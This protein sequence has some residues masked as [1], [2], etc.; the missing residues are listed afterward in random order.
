MSPPTRLTGTSR[1]EHPTPMSHNRFHIVPA[2]VV[3]AAL[4]AAAC[5]TSSRAAAAVS[6]STSG[7]VV[8]G[9]Q[10]DLG[11]IVIGWGRA[12]SDTEIT[13]PRPE[14]V[15]ARCTG[16]GPNLTVVIRAPHGWIITATEPSQTLTVD[17]TE[18]KLTGQID[19]TNQYLPTVHA[20]DWS[21]PDQ[22]DIAATAATPPSWKPA[23]GTASVYVSIHIDCH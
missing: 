19:T 3:A 2:V 8:T 1:K 12:H 16:H 6:A 13:T 9:D 22:L 4:C 14:Q 18:Q 10:T 17:N 20:V 15:N 23:S 5:G 11:S 21:Q 7:V